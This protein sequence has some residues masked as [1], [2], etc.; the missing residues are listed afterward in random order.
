MRCPCEGNSAL[1]LYLNTS[2]DGGKPNYVD[3]AHF[4]I[5]QKNRGYGSL[6]PPFPH[7]RHGKVGP[8]QRNLDELCVKYY[9]SFYV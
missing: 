8:I 6:P 9:K 3:V 5:C 7:T 4:L 2:A 1:I